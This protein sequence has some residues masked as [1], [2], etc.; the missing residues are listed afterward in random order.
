M[1]DA[2]QFP[3]PSAM[4]GS[5]RL[6]YSSAFSPGSGSGGGASSD[7][8]PIFQ[9]PDRATGF[10]GGLGPLS[11]VKIGAV[12]QEVSFAKERLDNVVEF[13]LRFPGVSLLLPQTESIVRASLIHKRTFLLPAHSPLSRVHAPPLNS[14]V[15]KPLNPKP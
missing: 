8:L 10:P 2:A 4:D 12:Y 15:T 13:T 3:W 1:Y 6:V 7:S 9:T 14:Q 11:P 5:W